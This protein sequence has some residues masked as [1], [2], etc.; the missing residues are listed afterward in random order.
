LH[1]RNI[2]HVSR[3][4]K[5]LV[6]VHRLATNNNAFLEFHL[7]CFIKDKATERS[8]LQGRCEGCLYPLISKQSRSKTS[9]QVLGVNRPSTAQWHSRLGHPAILIVKQVIRNFNLPVSNGLSHESVCGHCQQAKSHQLPYPKSTSVSKSPLEL[10]FSN[11]WGRAPM[12]VGRHTY[13]V[14]FIDD[15]SKFT[16]IYLFKHKY[17]VFQAFHNFHNLVERKLNKKILVM[18]SD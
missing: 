16:W 18:Q 17:D 15:Y 5:N 2:L 7:N 10:I 13:Y 1:L 4:S 9:R 8:L 11:V 3:S 12:S 6:F 14:S